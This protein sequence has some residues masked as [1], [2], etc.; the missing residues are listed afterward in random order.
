MIYDKTNEK[1][2]TNDPLMLLVKG[3]SCVDIKGF[4][5]IGG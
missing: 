3:V 1:I 4:T 5:R 2:Y